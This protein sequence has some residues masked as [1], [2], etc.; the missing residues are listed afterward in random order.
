MFHSNDT[1]GHQAGD[2]AL[3]ALAKC[4]SRVSGKKVRCYRVGGDEFA[5]L[6]REQSPEET[7]RMIA[8]I[9]ASLAKTPYMAAF[10]C[11]AHEENG[12][13]TEAFNRADSGMYKD[14]ARYKHRTRERK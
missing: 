9:R 14:K 10:G 7:R 11:A 12:N 3:C 13:F 1:Q 2:A 8:V 5:M 4:L 6:C